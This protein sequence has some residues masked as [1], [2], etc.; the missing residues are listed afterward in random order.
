MEPKSTAIYN[1]LERK[2]V[3]GNLK[4]G[5][6]LPSES[7]LCKKFSVSRGPVRAAL[8]KLSAIGLVFK[9]KGGGSY[10]SE[11]SMDNILNVILPS[12]KFNAGNLNQILEIRCALEKLSLELCLKNHA[13]NDYE[14]LD[15]AIKSM[16]KEEH[17]KE[18]FFY[19]DREFH[20]AISYLSGNPLLHMINQLIWDLLQSIPRDKY[21]ILSLEEII[22]EHKRIY[23]SIKEND[24]ELATL[25]TV[26]QLKRSYDND[27]NVTS[28]IIDKKRWNP[29]LSNTL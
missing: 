15:N 8:E 19:L 4:P 28:D 1:Y 20:T 21:Y 18:T 29:W 9:K 13:D 10:V 2:I 6:K 12:L 26:R 17:S 16:V 24:L 3:Q 14:L 11:Q 5:D 27:A 25:Y 7:E 23:K 22:V